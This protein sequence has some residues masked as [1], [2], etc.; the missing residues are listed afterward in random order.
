MTV[1]TPQ[2]TIDRDRSKARDVIARLYRDAEQHFR[3]MERKHAMILRIAAAAGIDLAAALG[4][5]P[6]AVA[7][8]A[9]RPAM[10]ERPIMILWRQGR[11]SPAQ[12]LAAE[13][14]TALIRLKERTQKVVGWASGGGGGGADAV[15]D[16][17][18]RALDAASEWG[19]L[20]A[21]V[22]MDERCGADIEHRRRVFVVLEL[23]C[24]AELSV[25][26]IVR[27]RS[28]L[29]NRRD[30]GRKLKTGLQVVAESLGDLRRHREDAAEGAG[31]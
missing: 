30:V 2:D 11:L 15:P 3:E 29:G 9:E 4:D 31:E 7:V 1:H 8:P 5:S 6:S 28:D 16:G 13:R 27:T 17:L 26:Q 18:A 24:G 10:R 22:L 20:Q 12:F 21:R 19:M 23:A 14:V 25:S